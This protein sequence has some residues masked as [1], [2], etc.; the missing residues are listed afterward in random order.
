MFLEHEKLCNRIKTGKEEME[1]SACEG[2]YCLK[3]NYDNDVCYTH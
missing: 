3:I 2:V 1:G